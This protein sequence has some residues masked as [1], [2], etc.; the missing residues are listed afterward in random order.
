MVV[1][2]IYTPICDNVS[3]TGIETLGREFEKEQKLN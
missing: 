1:T 3:N 2:V